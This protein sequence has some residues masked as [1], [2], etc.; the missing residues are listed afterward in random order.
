MNNDFSKDAATLKN[1]RYKAEMTLGDLSNFTNVGKRNL[2]KMEKA[3]IP[4]PQAIIMVLQYY[5]EYG[6][7]GNR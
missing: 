1:L 5:I 4:V 2:R 7:L 3:E 6:E